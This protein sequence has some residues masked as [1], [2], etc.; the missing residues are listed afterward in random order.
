[1]NGKGKKKNV[2]LVKKK[3]TMI[4][5]DDQRSIALKER[6]YDKISKVR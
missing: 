6:L 1:M 2:R 4:K 3:S 5:N